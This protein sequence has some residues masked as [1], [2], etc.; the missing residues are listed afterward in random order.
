MTGPKMVFFLKN[1]SNYNCKWLLKPPSL[2][3]GKSP[4]EK[5]VIKSVRCKVQ[6]VENPYVSIMFV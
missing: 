1:V 6:T 3:C 4:L 5:N 2:Y